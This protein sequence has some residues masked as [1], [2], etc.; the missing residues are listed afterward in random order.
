MLHY[1]ITC[2]GVGGGLGGDMKSP[3]CSGGMADV[4]HPRGGPGYQCKEIKH[5][6]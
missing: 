6:E 2:M 1:G 5:Q 3:A 4:T